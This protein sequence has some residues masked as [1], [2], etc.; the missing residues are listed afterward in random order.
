MIPDWDSFAEDLAGDTDGAEI[1]R[2]RL[3]HVLQ[4]YF[5]SHRI[6]VDLGASARAPNGILVNA[7]AM[8]CP[9]TPSEKQALLEA[10]TV[11]ERSRVMI[12]LMEM[13]IVQRAGGLD[14][15]SRH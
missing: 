15:V 1:D 9:F 14:D 3:L 4:N 11:G 2:E 12:T 7:M 5:A 13:A 8:L 10:A 6:A